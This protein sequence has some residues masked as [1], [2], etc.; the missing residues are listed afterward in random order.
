MSS[1]SILITGCSAGGIG[2][3]LALSFQARNFTVFATARSTEKMEDLAALPN[4]HL[5]PLDVTSPVSINTAKEKV[6][7]L[8]GGKLDVLI[9]NA[10]QVS[11]MPVL[12]VDIDEAKQQFEVNYWGTLRMVQAFGDMLIAAKGCI[13]N[14]GSLSGVLPLPFSSKSLSSHQPDS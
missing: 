6:S 9:N 2:H 7:E 11:T 5:L 14:V 8:T 1:Q 12:D 10:G 4:M 3:A 13:I